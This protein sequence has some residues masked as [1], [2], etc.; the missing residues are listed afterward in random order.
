M[1]R[2]LLKVAH[3][4]ILLLTRIIVKILSLLTMPVTSAIL[5]IIP[6]MFSFQV[7]VGQ[8]TDH[9]LVLLLLIFI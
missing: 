1:L 6:L 5:L 3:I 2:I 4:I 9:V 8:V 7:V